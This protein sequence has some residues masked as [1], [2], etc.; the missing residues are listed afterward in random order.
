[1]VTE[2]VYQLTMK[3]FF[4]DGVG[5]LMFL[6][7]ISQYQSRIIQQITCSIKTVFYVILQIIFT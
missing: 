3:Y 6:S 2:N 1:M 7:L 4:V 5:T